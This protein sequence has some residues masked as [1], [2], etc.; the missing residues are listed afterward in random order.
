MRN[1]TTPV[2]RVR[3]LHAADLTDG[4]LTASWHLA[5]LDLHNVACTVALH[6][7]INRAGA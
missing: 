3:V 4:K 7:Y 5:T 1:K 6:V 2:L